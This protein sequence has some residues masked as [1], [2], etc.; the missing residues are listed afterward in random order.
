MRQIG[1]A[2]VVAVGLALAPVAAEAEGPK[3]YRIGFLALQPFADLAPY[4]TALRQGLR[5]HAYV[6]GQ[7]LVIES[8][9]ADSLAR[10]GGNLSGFSLIAVE[11][12]GKRLELFKEAIPSLKLAII[13]CHRGSPVNALALKE[14]EVAAH[15]LGLEARLVEVRDADE[16]EPAFTTIA[17]ERAHGV[18]LVP[19][20]F[21]VTHGFRITELATRSGSRCSVGPTCRPEKVPSCHTVRAPPMYF[22]AL[23]GTSRRSPSNSRPNSS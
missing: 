23:E 11:L 16:L 6:E 21:L 18:V 8:R 3:V 13:F 17:R 15:K 12:T 14:A 7:N 19:S 20:S 5:E 2:V 1:L 22:G 4:A 10:P 9:F